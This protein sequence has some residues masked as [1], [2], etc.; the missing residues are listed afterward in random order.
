MTKSISTDISL[1]TLTKF[2][3]Y[4]TVQ[5]YFSLKPRFSFNNNKKKIY[6]GFEFSFIKNKSVV[7]SLV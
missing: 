6:Y 3:L 2:D 5:I 7:L 1:I 4:W